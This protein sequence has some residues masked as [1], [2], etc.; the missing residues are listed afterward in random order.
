MEPVARVFSSH[1]EAE[2]AE[3]EYY[4]A[5]TPEQRIEIM[6]EL[7]EMV[8]PEGDG[9]PPRLERVYRA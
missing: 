2:Q 9:T 6:L 8:W 5:L 3:I 4:R 7:L 1:E